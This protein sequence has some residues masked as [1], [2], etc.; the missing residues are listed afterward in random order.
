MKQIQT[1]IA[2]IINFSYAYIICI[3]YFL[4]IYFKILLEVIKQVLFKKDRHTIQ[5][6]L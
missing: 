2:N 3:I 1:C 6:S 4:Q 5:P